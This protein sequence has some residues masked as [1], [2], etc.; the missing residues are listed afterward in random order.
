[1]VAGVDAGLHPALGWPLDEPVFDSGRHGL[2]IWPTQ[3]SVVG[4]E[5]GLPGCQPAPVLGGPGQER[6]LQPA[7]AQTAFATGPSTLPLA[8]AVF[9]G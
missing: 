4:L 8:R 3:N 9:A 1:M 7:G 6:P 5:P 2:G